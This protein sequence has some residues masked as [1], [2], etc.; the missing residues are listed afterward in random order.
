MILEIIIGFIIANKIDKF[1][2]RISD[3]D[4]KTMQE[5]KIIK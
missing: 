5:L 3:I 2:N 1:H 4:N